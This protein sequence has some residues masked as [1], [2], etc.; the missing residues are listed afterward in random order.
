MTRAW[1]VAIATHAAREQIGPVP[2]DEGI[3]WGWEAWLDWVRARGFDGVDVSTGVAPVERSD[4]WWRELAAS[5]RRRDLEL[6]SINCLRSSLADPEHWQLGDARIRRAIDVAAMLGIPTVNVSLAI[7]PER[8]DANACRLQASPLGSSRTATA[9]QRRATAERLRALVP[10]R[11]DGPAVVLE[12]HHASIADTAPSA[13]ELAATVGIP[14]NP[15]LVN[16]LW[17]FDEPERDWADSLRMCAPVSGGIWHVKNCRRVVRPDGAI[18]FHDAPLDDGDLD[19][20]EALQIMADAGFEGWLS[21]ERSGGDD[22]PATAERGI[23]FLHTHGIGR[24]RST[25]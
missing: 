12:L 3:W 21:I 22:F 7:P 20:V 23:D 15:D 6:A 5:A 16:E 18:E 24:R 14:L 13:I 2:D 9:A 10:A 4:D 17:A 8:G 25:Q 11:S 19:Y 1:P